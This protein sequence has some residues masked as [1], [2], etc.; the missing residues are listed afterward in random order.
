MIKFFNLPQ[1]VIE[2][3]ALHLCYKN[4]SN[5]QKYI[6]E[7]VKIN[8]KILKHFSNYEK[9]VF[10]NSVKINDKTLKHLLSLSLVSKFMFHIIWKNEHFWKK[11]FEI[12]FYDLERYRS[13][14][15]HFSMIRKATTNNPYRCNNCKYFCTRLRIYQ[16]R[17]PDEPETAKITCEICKYQRIV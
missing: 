5:Y 13:D 16:I 2:R 17:S 7:S 9:Y 1:E 6:C 12:H 8:D 3:V 15:T 14:N 11:A 4:I 10:E